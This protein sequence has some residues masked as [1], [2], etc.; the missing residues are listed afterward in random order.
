MLGVIVNFTEKS[1]KCSIQSKKIH[2]MQY[3][4]DKLKVIGNL[5][6]SHSLDED[7]LLLQVLD[8]LE[9]VDLLRLT[10]TSSAMH[11]MLQ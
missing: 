1:K 5:L 4:K 6:L 11:T 2:A 8:M 9:D 7:G 3:N 10:H